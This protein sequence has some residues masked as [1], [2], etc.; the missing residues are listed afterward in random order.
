VVEEISHAACRNF[1][2]SVL[3]LMLS[4]SDVPG[5][6]DGLL[7]VSDR[8]SEVSVCAPFFFSSLAWFNDPPINHTVDEEALVK[9]EGDDK[10]GVCNYEERDD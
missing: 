7:T 3:A 4:R 10:H 9:Q 5:D 6:L 2:V 1:G 8:A